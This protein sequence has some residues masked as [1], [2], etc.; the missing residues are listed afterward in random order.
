MVKYLRQHAFD[1]EEFQYS[2]NTADTKARAINVLGA[3]NV[4]PAFYNRGLQTPPA[5]A[6]IL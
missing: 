4:L 2:F 5:A 3:R 6:N 1:L